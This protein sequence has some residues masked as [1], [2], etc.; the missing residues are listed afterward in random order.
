[1]VEVNSVWQ[2]Y[3]EFLNIF[4][5]ACNFFGPEVL[6][7]DYPES[8]VHQYSRV[9]LFRSHW[10]KKGL[11]IIRMHREKRVKKNV[12]DRSVMYSGV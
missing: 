9:Q 2:P 11:Q 1:M 8:T 4:A 3:F 12:G 10:D 7:L 5:T 6:T